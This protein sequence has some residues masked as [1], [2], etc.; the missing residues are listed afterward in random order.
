QSF[1]RSSGERS[2]GSSRSYSMNPVGLPIS[3]ASPNDTNHSAPSAFGPETAPASDRVL[4][5]SLNRK[6][7]PKNVAGEQIAEPRMM[8]E[9]LTGLTTLDGQSYQ[10]PS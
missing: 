8:A 1:T 5:S 2:A 6:P 3:Q 7:T 4:C 10:L 9:Y